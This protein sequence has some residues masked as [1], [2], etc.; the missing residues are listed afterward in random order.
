MH[1]LFIYQ[2]KCIM[3]KIE[4]V[5]LKSDFITPKSSEGLAALHKGEYAGW[6]F[7]KCVM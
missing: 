4:L 6:W 5:H 7:F 2:N 1:G 3:L